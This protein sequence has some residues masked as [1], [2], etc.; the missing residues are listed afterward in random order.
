MYGQRRSASVGSEGQRAAPSR[1]EC[2]DLARMKRPRAWP[3]LIPSCHSGPAGTVVVV[4]SVYRSMT[5]SESP[6]CQSVGAQ[7]PT[8]SARRS[9]LPRS[10]WSTVLARIQRPIHRP[11]EPS[12]SRWKC[13]P[14]RPLRC[15]PSTITTPFV[16]VPFGFSRTLGGYRQLRVESALHPAASLDG[17]ALARWHCSDFV[18]LHVADDADAS[19][20]G[21]RRCR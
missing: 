13:D 1:G 7:R 14:R 15:N 19:Q 11:T 8:K 6:I 17:G 3:R 2:A 9:A 5:L 10:S 4:G 16:P 21:E 20:R 18:E 12:E